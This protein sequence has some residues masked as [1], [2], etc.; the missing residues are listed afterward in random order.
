MVSSW[1]ERMIS[2]TGTETQPRILR[3]AAVENFLQWDDIKEPQCYYSNKHE[4]YCCI[5][6]SG[7]NRTYMLFDIALNL[8]SLTLPAKTSLLSGA[9]TASASSSLPLGFANQCIEPQLSIGEGNECQRGHW[10]LRSGR[11]DPTS[12]GEGNETFFTR[13]WIVTLE[14]CGLVGTNRLDAIKGELEK[15]FLDKMNFVM[16]VVANLGL[17]ISV[18][19]IRSVDRGFIFPSDGVAMYKGE[20]STPVQGM[21]RSTLQPMWVLTDYDSQPYDIYETD[22]AAIDCDGVGTY[23]MMEW[24]GRCRC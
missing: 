21:L 1:S 9:A 19:D 13:F 10:P 2:H 16:N 15:L 12:V 8:V 22:E 11:L 3:E 23:F 6:V 7:S 18:Y 5:F 14:E 24:L 17:C 4:T 20:V